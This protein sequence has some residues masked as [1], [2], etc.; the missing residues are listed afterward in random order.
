MLI[1]NKPVV[2]ESKQ[3][4]KLL[5]ENLMPLALKLLQQL[6][7]EPKLQGRPKKTPCIENKV[8]HNI[9]VEVKALNLKD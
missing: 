1:A 6:V 4:T 3:G 7:K 5:V 9:S 8:E 2:N